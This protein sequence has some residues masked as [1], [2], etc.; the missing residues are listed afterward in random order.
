[1]CQH[2]DKNFQI[3]WTGEMMNIFYRGFLYK[4]KLFI[5]YRAFINVWALFPKGKVFCDVI[6]AIICIKKFIMFNLVDDS[7][8]VIGP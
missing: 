6:S 8:T 7:D 2:L 5:F 3:K 1:M 4:V